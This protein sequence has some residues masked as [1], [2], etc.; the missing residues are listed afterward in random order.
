MAEI[1]LIQTF[2]GSFD[3]MSTRLP[4]SLL[5]VASVPVSK[6]YDVLIA[7]QRVSPNFE[8]EI[9]EG[10]GPETVIFGLTAITGPQIRYGMEISK[11]LKARY[12]DIPICW[13]GVH[14]TLLPEQTVAHPLVDFVVVGDGE[15]VFCELFECLRDGKSYE[16]LRGI[17]YKDLNEQVVSNAGYVETTHLEKTNSVKYVRKNGAADVIRDLDSLPE[18]PYHL[19][20]FDS[21]KVFDDP[22]G[23]KSAT[24]N[25]SRG[26]PFRC[27]FCSDPVINAGAWRGVS[28]ERLLQKVDNLYTNHGVELIYFQDDYFPGS[29]KRF[30]Q[31]LEGLAKYEGK[32]GWT[33]L[34]VR[35]DTITKLTD[36]E[37]D[38]LKDSG[39]QSLEVGIESGNE[40]VIKYLNKA[41]T[42]DEMRQANKML[43]R[44]DI[45]VKY[46]LIVGFPSETDEEMMD[47]VKFALELERDN[48][49]AYCLIFNFL[50]IIGTPFY[51]DAVNAGFKSPE[52][53]EDWAHM[54][55]ENWMKNFTSW[56]SPKK[57]RRLEAIS[58]I[59]YFH[60]KN[61]AHKFGGSMLLRMSFKLYHPI[62][63]WRFTN[64][65]FDYFIEAT[66][67]NVLLSTKYFLR[68]MIRKL[69]GGA[70]SK[71]LNHEERAS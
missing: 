48:P 12:P 18:L 39:C 38:L 40:R 54:D 41:E 49:N 58:L 66:A 3:E 25:T 26:C 46:T 27:K 47:T 13:G 61:V 69:D 35:A 34:G 52:S 2:V 15:Y 11:F 71:Q 1:V 31:I 32:I 14:A 53:L 24:L 33:T 29:R 70:R 36:Q 67:K 6:G 51:V 45:V 5:A 63:K 10:V 68:D 55:F 42:L 19:V 22:K 21:Y 64:L 23:R 37:L 57:A 59:S 43:A 56:I 20:D 44:L 7:D 50:P 8:N 30:V 4:E 62:A 65:Y 9:I 60:N 16:D 17:A 28:A